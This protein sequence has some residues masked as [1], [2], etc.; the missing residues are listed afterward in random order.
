MTVIVFGHLNIHESIEKLGNLTRDQRTVFQKAK[1]ALGQLTT[2]K[3]K[4]KATNRRL[5]NQLE[6]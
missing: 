6:E 5:E 2:E 1:K 3:A 4:L